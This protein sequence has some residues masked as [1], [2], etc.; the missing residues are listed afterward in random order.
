MGTWK[1]A[2]VQIDSRL[3]DVAFNLKAVRAGLRDAARLGARLA[4]FPDAP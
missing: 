1:I 4:V 3:G 2:A